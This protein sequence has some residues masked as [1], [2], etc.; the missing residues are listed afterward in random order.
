MKKLLIISTILF[1]FVISCKN[2]NITSNNGN[3]EIKFI[4]E[5]ENHD[6]VFQSDDIIKIKKVIDFSGN[7]HIYKKSYENYLNNGNYYL[8]KDTIINKEFINSLDSIFIEYDFKEFP[9]IIPYDVDTTE[10]F[11]YPYHIIKISWRQNKTNE[12]K[13]VQVNPSN[14]TGK[15][16]EKFKGFEN[17]LIYL[18]N[19]SL[20]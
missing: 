13:K 10:P 20:L 14:G 8:A 3:Q 11:M 17:S 1:C 12:I 4:Y 18:F 16:P 6:N 19:N 9:S 7:L 2:D 15:Y 5:V